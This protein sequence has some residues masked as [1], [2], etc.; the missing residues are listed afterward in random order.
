MSLD[1]KREALAHLFDYYCL[2][3]FS[4]SFIEPLL[5]STDFLADCL[6]DPARDADC[7]EIASKNTSFR[8]LLLDLYDVAPFDTGRI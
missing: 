1:E 4:E 3:L 2:K 6:A 7:R 8:E 5:S